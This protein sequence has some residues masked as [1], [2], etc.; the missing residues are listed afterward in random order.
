MAS[1]QAHFISVKATSTIIPIGAHC[2]S[3]PSYQ[4][5]G[6]PVFFHPEGKRYAHNRTEEGISVVTEADV[7]HPEV[8]DRIDA[9]L[10]E[11][12]ALAAEKDVEIPDSADVFIELDPHSGACYYWIAD[13][14]N[15]AIFW[16]HEVDTIALGLPNSSS[17]GNLQYA[18]EENYWIHVEMFPI[19]AS[20][21][22]S[23]ALNE[24]QIILLHAHADALTS[25]VP[26]FPYTAEEC[27]RFTNLL[28]C[29][30]DSASNPYVTTFVARLWV[31]VANHR[32]FTHFGE[33][34]CRMSAVHS[35]LEAPVKKQSIF[36]TAIS[37][38][39]FNIPSEHTER[40]ERLWVDDLVYTSAWRKHVSER[41]EDLRLKMIWLFALMI[42]NIL[43]LPISQF[44]ALNKS[45][46]LF[47]ILGECIT[48]VLFQEQR[49]LDGT[50]A[51]TG[52][53][54][55]DTALLKFVLIL[56]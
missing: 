18:L 32:F 39:L 23:M 3:A 9:C 27:E 24:L 19:T 6:W 2:S 50:G 13:H 16:V 15:R 17:K 40:L 29:S 49:K 8:A 36:L 26:T 14:A 10:A 11:I 33:D 25:D 52:V 28:R 56:P 35:V 30:R 34:Q 41:V 1:P 54:T 21:Y 46:I 22:S 20:Q 37:K 47:C 38:A 51:A 48:L 12:R 4:S 44:P 43:M 53:S 5:Y 7:N 42:A 31:I 55:L 45:S